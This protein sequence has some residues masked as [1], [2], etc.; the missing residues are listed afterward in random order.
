MYLYLPGLE[1]ICWL[2]LVT[3]H[4]C[5]GKYQLCH[6]SITPPPPSSKKYIE[7]SFIVR[8]ALKLNA[9]KMIELYIKLDLSLYLNLPL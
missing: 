2:A 1:I 7:L 5:P 3:T 9:D 4:I 8:A 6:I